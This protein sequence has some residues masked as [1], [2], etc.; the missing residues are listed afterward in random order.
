MPEG[1]LGSSPEEIQA[2][3]DFGYKLGPDSKPE[4]RKEALRDIAR[5]RAL[6][7][8]WATEEEN[9]YLIGDLNK[10]IKELKESLEVTDKWVLDNWDKLDNLA[11]KYTI[12][13]L[14]PASPKKF[15]RID[16][17]SGFSLLVSLED[18]TPY[19]DGYRVKLEIGNPTTAVYVG[20][21]MT[22]EWGPFWSHQKP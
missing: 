20:Y 5:T 18:V 17:L 9:R 10:Q 16:S 19:L 4:D 6:G 14:S 13:E 11:S 3:I 1:G 12:A 21:K 15:I 22:V 2:A 7:E 8:A